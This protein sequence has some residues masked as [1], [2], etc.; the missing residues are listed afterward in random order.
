VRSFY[1]LDKNGTAVLKGKDII[2]EIPCFILKKNQK[3]ISISA[4]DFSFMAENNLSDI[5]KILYNYKL[6]VN[7]I[8]N[9][10]LSFSV[11]IEDKFNNFE[12]LIRELKLSYKVDFL[13]DV[14]LYTIRHANDISISEIENK[15]KVLLKQSTMGI[16]KVVMQ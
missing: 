15:G 9:S 14:S 13:E 10:A 6:K 7:L 3:L 2:P 5:F 1:D 8:Q 4:L 12:L 11:C 16:V